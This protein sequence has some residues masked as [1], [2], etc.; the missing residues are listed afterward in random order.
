MNPH[1][2]DIRCQNMMLFLNTGKNNLIVEFCGDPS[3]TRQMKATPS[4]LRT[5][6]GWKWAPIALN[7]QLTNQYK[8]VKWNFMGQS[9]CNLDVCNTQ[10]NYIVTHILASCWYSIHK[11]HFLSRVFVLTVLFTLT[12]SPCCIFT[13]LLSFWL[14]GP[15]WLQ[16]YFLTGPS[17]IQSNITESYI[18]IL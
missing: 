15:P 14:S 18:T 6:V 2:I 11:A 1:I 7:P 9:H 17:P 13:H 5:E 3:C 16:Y 4:S 8:R 10:Q 12:L